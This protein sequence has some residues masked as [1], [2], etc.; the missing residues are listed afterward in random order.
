MEKKYEK[1]LIIEKLDIAV[2][3]TIEKDTADTKNV[4]KRKG[5][6]NPNYISVN[7]LKN[8]MLFIEFKD[9]FM[10]ELFNERNELI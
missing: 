4:L 10:E 8:E 5:I 6:N 1:E 3:K 7:E 2:K 9:F